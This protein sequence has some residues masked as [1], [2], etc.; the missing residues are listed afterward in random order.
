MARRMDRPAAT[1]GAQRRGAKWR[2]TAVYREHAT[3]LLGVRRAPHARTSRWHAHC[4]SEPLARGGPRD[5]AGRS[6]ATTVEEAAAGCTLSRVQPLQPV[7]APRRRG[8]QGDR[9]ALGIQV[10]GARSGRARSQVAARRAVVATREAARWRSSAC[11]PDQRDA[12]R[13]RVVD[14]LSYGEIAARLDGERADGTRARLA[15]PAPTRRRAGDL[16]PRSRR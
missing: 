2:S 4:R 3:R 11:R 10:H 1:S 5:H 15:R 14:E 13:L 9:S 12:V 16:A 8:A 7:R 6:A